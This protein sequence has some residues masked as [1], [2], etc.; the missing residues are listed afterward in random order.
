MAALFEHLASPRWE[1]ERLYSHPVRGRGLGKQPRGCERM[2]DHDGRDF[3]ANGDYCL[4]HL[5]Y[6]PIFDST[7]QNTPLQDETAERASG[8]QRSANRNGSGA[9]AASR[10]RPAN[11]DQHDVRLSSET[12]REIEFSP[13]TLPAPECVRVE[14][15]F[16]S[17]SG[18]HTASE[19]N[20][21]PCSPQNALLS[22]FDQ[23]LD[24][25]AGRS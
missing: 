13:A 21:A 19:K 25:I 12:H 9:A 11:A 17:R 14:E 6:D 3:P 4:I 10:W 18:M 1:G 8:R 24:L 23:S 5:N 15:D 7:G 20:R 2:G 22:F 16:T